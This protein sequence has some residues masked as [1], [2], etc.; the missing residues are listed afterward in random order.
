M[1]VLLES[2]LLPG[3]ILLDIGAGCLG[4]GK[5][6]LE[7]LDKRD[8][9]AIEPNDWLIEVAGVARSRY[10]LYAFDDFRL[11]RI[12]KKFDYVLAHSIFTHADRSQIRTILKETRKVLICNMEGRANGFLAASFYDQRHGDS[13][14]EGWCYPA[15]VAYTAEFI[16]G[17]ARDVGWEHLRVHRDERHPAKH[18]WLFG[19]M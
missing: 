17:L 8:Y 11:S 9:W 5:L 7:Y 16:V 14:H 19:R 15:G 12:R 13:E 6:V 18:T 3:H 10:H 4:P 2:G 1:A